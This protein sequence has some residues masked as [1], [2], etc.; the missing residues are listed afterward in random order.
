[1]RAMQLMQ[2]DLSRKLS[3]EQ[4]AKELGVSW[5]TLAHVFPGV[6]GETLHQLP[7]QTA[8]TGTCGIQ[9]AEHASGANLECRP[10]QW[11]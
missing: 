9:P 5:S 8:A 6:V 2:R 10:G 4:L 3:V 11:F 7:R 1:M